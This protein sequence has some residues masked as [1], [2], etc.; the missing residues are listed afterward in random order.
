VR[1]ASGEG[2]ERGYLLDPVELVELAHQE[3]ERDLTEEECQRYLRR[4][5]DGSDLTGN[6]RSSS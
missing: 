2:V 5:C 1:V 6:S 3:V 4:S